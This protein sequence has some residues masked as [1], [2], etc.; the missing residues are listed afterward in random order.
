MIITLIC[1]GKTDYSFVK[2]GIKIY[3]DRIVHYLP[4]NRIEIPELK[5]TKSLSPN[6]I[7]EKEA[8][9][10][11]KQI[12]PTD[13]V[14]LLDE[15]GKHFSSTQWA[16]VIE[17]EMIQ[18][19]RNLTFVIGGAYGFSNE[20][21]ERANDKLSLSEMTFSHQIIRVIFTEQL[22]RAMTIIKGEPY[23]NE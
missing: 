17:K 16:K 22:Y 23:H 5:S 1:V 12:K 18:G 2:D 4:Y 21:Y 3:E 14:V 7:K 15:K 10:I 6:Q 11:L 8:V 13:K 9:L 20:I 19:T